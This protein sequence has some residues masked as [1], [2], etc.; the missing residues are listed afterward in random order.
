MA[1]PAHI[2]INLHSEAVKCN[3]ICM[4]KRTPPTHPHARRR[5][6]ALG[7]RLRMARLRRK[8]SQAILAERVG[9]SVP[10]IGKLEDGDPTTSLATMLRVLGVLGMA[11]DIDLLAAE[12]TLGRS[13]QDSS[14]KRPAPVPPINP[15]EPTRTREDP[16]ARLRVRKVPVS[17]PGQGTP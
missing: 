3:L 6:T 13:L 11:A 4:S 15:R 12:D 5:L 2:K 9:V 16:P 14:L 10:T 8:M 7:M 1:G 17:T